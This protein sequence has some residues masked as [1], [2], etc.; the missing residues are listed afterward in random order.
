[1]LAGIPA[2]AAAAGGPAAAKA[3]LGICPPGR[4]IALHRVP[5]H[6]EEFL[7]VVHPLGVRYESC[8]SCGEPHTGQ[9]SA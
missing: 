1:M 3:G 2:A 9:S 6:Q 8:N 7:K 4:R 5:T